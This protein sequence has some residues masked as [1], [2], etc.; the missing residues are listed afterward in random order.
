MKHYF[1]LQIFIIS[2]LSLGCNLG[3]SNYSQF[4]FNYGPPLEYIGPRLNQEVYNTDLDSLLEYVYTLKN[5]KR[6]SLVYEWYPNRY[7]ENNINFSVLEIREGR[8]YH[9]DTLYS[10][11]VFHS[12]YNPMN[13]PTIDYCCDTCSPLDL[14]LKKDFIVRLGK[15][16]SKETY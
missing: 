5:G 1:T 16:I 15:I 8:Y 6:D 3:N 2:I 4:E 12:N 9:N 11:N 10:G 13:N 7:V 14:F